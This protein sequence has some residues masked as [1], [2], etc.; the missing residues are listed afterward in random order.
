MGVKSYVRF[1]APYLLDYQ[2]DVTVT[3]NP[4]TF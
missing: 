4:L 2:R 1:R 3:P